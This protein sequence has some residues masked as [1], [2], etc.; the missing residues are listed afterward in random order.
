MFKKAVKAVIFLICPAGLSYAEVTSATLHNQKIRIVYDARWEFNAQ[1]L[2][3]AFE[4][5]KKEFSANNR[6]ESGVFSLFSI[7]LNTQVL[8][9]LLTGKSCMPIKRWKR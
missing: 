6:P 2:L 5:K 7:R 3:S 4:A 8:Q 1:E 9:Q